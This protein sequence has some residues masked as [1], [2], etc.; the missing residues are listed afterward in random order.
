MGID[1]K[2]SQLTAL[3]AI[4]GTELM[5]IST[6][7][8]NYTI[9]PNQLASFLAYSGLN[10]YVPTTGAGT[11]IGTLLGLTSYTQLDN[12]LL[13]FSVTNANTGDST[14]NLN[15]LGAIQ[16]LK[17]GN[18]ILNANDFKTGQI[19]VGTFVPTGM[20]RKFQVISVT[21]NIVD[22]V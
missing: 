11:Y 7:G 13:N 5:P 12:R 19:I 10:L 22:A 6:G 14:I 20:T 16:L 8:A 17:F 1:Q 15:G 21:D 2:I 9:T 18:A 3:G 4:S